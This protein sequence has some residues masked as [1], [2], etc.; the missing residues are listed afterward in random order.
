MSFSIPGVDPDD[1]R[2]QRRGAL[3]VP[4]GEGITK[5]VSG[6]VYTMKATAST[7]GG[8]LGF[9]EA[10]VPPGRGTS[11]HAHG[12]EIEAFYLLAGELEFVDGDRRFTAGQGDFVFVPAGIRHSF[13]NR[14]VHTARMIFLFSPGGPEEMFVE[15]GDEP[16]PGEQSP[17]WGP[18]KLAEILPA[19]ARYNVDLLPDLD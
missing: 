4:A 18:E 14:G 3:Y 12:T 2:Y 11:P 1:P 19:I 16:R 13:M 5:W 7:T 6:D 10:S 15:S 17:A 9:I 8:A